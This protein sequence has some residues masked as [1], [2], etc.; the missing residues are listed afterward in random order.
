MTRI[1][2]AVGLFLLAPLMGEY[3]IGNIPATHLPGLIVLAPMYGG[4][5]LLIREVTRRTRRGWPT[6][7]TLA[8]AYG[9]LQP[10]VIDQS[11]FNPSFDGH[12]FTAAPTHLPALGLD[13]G[14]LLTFTAGHA[15]TTLAVPIA[16]I[17]ALAR[18]RADQPWLRTP[19]LIVTTL[20]FAAGSWLIYDD[21]QRT[22]QASPTQLTISALVV[23]ALTAAAFTFRPGG[24]RNDRTGESRGPAAAKHL[25]PSAPNPSTNSAPS[26]APSTAPSVDSGVDSG[27]D[28]SVSRS[29][30][31]GVSPAPDPA[32]CPAPSPATSLALSLGARPAPRP[33]QVAV[34]VFALDTAETLRPETWP[35]LI[36]GAG[37]LAGAALVITRWAARPGW[38]RRHITCLAAGAA[39]TPMWTGFLLLHLTGNATPANLTGQAL[40]AATALAVVTAA[41]RAAR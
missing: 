6:L 30:D 31:P 28:R 9:L 16:L 21:H 19:G 25:R 36:A 17:E 11:L 38:S 40:V 20:L 8:T 26:T 14:L 27:V 5:A 33:W 41:V 39:L 24:G 29:V 3:L 37:I 18:H 35:G 2:L 32:P 12:D 4:A 10:A 15:I 1:A 34:A 23:M 13:P 7:L 22:F